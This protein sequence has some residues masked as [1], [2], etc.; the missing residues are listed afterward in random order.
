MRTA[1]QLLALIA[2]LA[3]TGCIFGKHKQP[4]P[5]VVDLTGNK[6][7]TTN[8]FTITPDQS[9]TGSV[10]SVNSQLRFVV[11][12][13]PFGELP[14][15][16]ARMNVFRNNAIVGEITITGPAHDN[17]TVADIVFGEAQKGDEVRAK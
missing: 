4:P 16:G 12:T 7:P 9:L 1:A 15:V 5:N 11:L 3:A 14:P 13:F 2:A 10:A 6:A 8:T 17:N